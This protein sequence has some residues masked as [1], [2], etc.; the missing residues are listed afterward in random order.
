MAPAVDG[1]GPREALRHRSD[2]GC[3]EG[4]EVLLMARLLPSCG[5][6]VPVAQLAVT[7]QECYRGGGVTSQSRL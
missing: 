3:S 7:R 6:F 4:F 2:L 1:S 5:E